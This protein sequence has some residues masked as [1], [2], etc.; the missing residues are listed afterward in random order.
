MEGN[1]PKRIAFDRNIV[2]NLASQMR[3]AFASIASKTGS[4]SPGELTD[5]LEHISCGSLLLGADLC[6]QL[7]EQARILDGDYGLGGEVL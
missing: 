7:V 3:V 5:D 1:C 4:R 2:P 6:A